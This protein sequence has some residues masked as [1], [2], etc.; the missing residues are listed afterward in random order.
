MPSKEHSDSWYQSFSCACVGVP[1]TS[2]GRCAGGTGSIVQPAAVSPFPLAVNR[3][4]TPAA[5]AI[6][7]VLTTLSVEVYCKVLGEVRGD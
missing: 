1:R 2:A 5:K 7:I 4:E 6:H 3:V